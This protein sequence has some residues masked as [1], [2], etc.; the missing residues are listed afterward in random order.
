MDGSDCCEFYHT[1][2]AFYMP[3]FCLKIYKI[4]YV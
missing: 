4:K 3:D 2:V 1:T